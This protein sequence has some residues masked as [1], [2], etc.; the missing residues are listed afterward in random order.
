[1]SDDNRPLTEEEKKKRKKEERERKRNE[2]RA[3]AEK[4]KRFALT[5]EK[6]RKLKI[7]IMKQ[8]AEAL[9]NE[10]RAKA[11]AKKKYLDDKVKPIPDDLYGCNEA[12]LVSLCKELHRC[13]TETHNTKYDMEFA[14]RKRDYEI[15]ELTVKVN[16]IKGKFIK[17]AL[18]KVSKT[19]SKFAKI[20]KLEQAQPD[21]K[22]N[23]KSS[24]KN[25]FALEEEKDDHKVDFRESLKSAKEHNAEE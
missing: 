14:I 13:I 8:A 11:E 7:L 18:K 6:K 10:T 16:D 1:M 22:T 5:P 17:P 3:N 12:Q 19:K 9:E 24:G 23:L 2:A 20:E 4:K 25:K 21:F 15:N